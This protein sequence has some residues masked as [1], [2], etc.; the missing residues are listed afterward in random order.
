MEKKIKRK[1][2]PSRHELTSWRMHVIRAIWHIAA[3]HLFSPGTVQS[4]VAKFVVENSSVHEPFMKLSQNTKAVPCC[5]H[6]WNSD[7]NGS[8]GLNWW[9]HQGETKNMC[10]YCIEKVADPFGY[11]IP[12]S[13]C[14]FVDIK[15]SLKAVNT[16]FP[17]I[18][19]ELAMFP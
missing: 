17:T 5:W 14:V 2:S 12:S 13:W 3:S 18:C 1:K 6:Y 19:M 11:L 15:T 7:V 10:A 4:T 8:S 9:S 16:Q